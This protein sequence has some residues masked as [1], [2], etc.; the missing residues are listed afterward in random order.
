MIGTLLLI[1]WGASFT[2]CMARWSKRYQAGI[3]K[4][5]G[6]P[7]PDEAFM[8][9]LALGLIPVLGAAY[10]IGGWALAREQA[11]IKRQKELAAEQARTD[12]I[13]AEH[14]VLP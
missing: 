14:S 2:G 6:E 4:F 11:E 5:S 7:D 8:G 9:H 12:R 3:Y 1:L 13:L 10:L